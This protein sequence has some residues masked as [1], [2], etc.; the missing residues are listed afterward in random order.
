[1]RRGL[2]EPQALAGFGACGGQVILETGLGHQIAKENV[3]NLAAG[4]NVA[5]IM[6]AADHAVMRIIV[7]ALE[8]LPAF[9]RDDLDQSERLKIADDGVPAGVGIGLGNS[10]ANRMQRAI[11]LIGTRAL[12]LHF[13]RGGGCGGFAVHAI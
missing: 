1:M 3:G 2:V 11:E 4:G 6:Y 12:E 5:G 9:L 7:G 10:P 13:E 8:D